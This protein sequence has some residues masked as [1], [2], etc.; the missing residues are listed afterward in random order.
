MVSSYH[1]PTNSSRKENPFLQ[2]CSLV[3]YC[4]QYTHLNY[5]YRITHRQEFNEDGKSP[6]ILLRVFCVRRNIIA[7]EKIEIILQKILKIIS[8]STAFSILLFQ[9][10]HQMKVKDKILIEFVKERRNGISPR[11]A[12]TSVPIIAGIRFLFL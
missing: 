7:S 2:F 1:S 9:L 11:F 8:R 3:L 6:R 5:V 12:L 10:S 4:T